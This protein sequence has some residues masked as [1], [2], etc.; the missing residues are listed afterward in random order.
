MNQ[1]GLIIQETT[2][3]SNLQFVSNHLDVNS[4]EIKETITDER[5]LASQLANMSDVYA[6]QITKNYKV[7]SLIV[8]N[9]TDFLGRSGFYAIRLYG[10]KGVNLTNFEG[11][12][13]NIKEK[14][15]TYTNTNNLNSQNYEDIL[16][17]IL[18]VE[19]NRKNFISLKIS[20]NCF[21]Y[22]EETN[23]NLSNVFNSNGVNLVHK[24][25]AFNRN[26]AVNENIAINAGLKSFAQINASLKETNIINNDGLL[27]DLK[28]NNQSVQFN[29][30]LSEL[31]LISNSS[32][33]IAYNTKDD[34]VLKTINNTFISIERKII[35]RPVSSQ[36]TYSS[37]GSKEKSSSQ[38]ALIYTVI[39]VLM[40]LLAGGFMFS[41]EIEKMI[42]PKPVV[43]NNSPADEDTK[44]PTPSL[45]TQ[46]EIKFVLETSSGKDSVY[47]T[48]YPK[49]DKYRFKFAGNKWSF[50]NN[51]KNNGYVDFYKETIEEINKMDSLNIDKEKFIESLEMI[52]TKKI[53]TKPVEVEKAQGANTNQDNSNPKPNTSKS[54]ELKKKEKT[55]QKVDETK[56]TISNKV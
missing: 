44:N 31:Y 20:Y 18:I 43:A 49:L 45:Q 1:F 15:N 40:V 37:R 51:Q 11:I 12:L 23:T 48:D 19:N 24:V 13:A 47:Q 38:D 21:Y 3:G 6:V 26:K 33:A 27:N 28:I 41:G 56:E 4:T 9:L 25:Y 52:S 42:H 14:F 53:K 50:K 35:H 32:D 17:S 10:P 29:P 36:P 8:T 16:S 34:K 7:Y 5:M 30:N 39:I 2:A 46:D 22:F 54:T 55:N